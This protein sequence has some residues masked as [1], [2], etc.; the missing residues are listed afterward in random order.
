ML[1]TFRKKTWDRDYLRLFFV[2]VL[3]TL[4]QLVVL[5]SPVSWKLYVS[6][7]SPVVAIVVIV[8]S[9]GDPDQEALKVPIK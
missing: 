6:I 4:F 1:F 2:G 8:L 9:L 3:S 5:I 7:A